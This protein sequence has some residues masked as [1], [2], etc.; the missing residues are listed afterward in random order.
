MLNSFFLGK[1]TTQHACWSKAFEVANIRTHVAD[2]IMRGIFWFFM[3]FIQHCFICRPS[4]F[5]VSEDAGIEPRTVATSTLAVRRSNRSARSHNN[6]LTAWKFN[7]CCRLQ[8]AEERRKSLEVSWSIFYI[9]SA[10]FVNERNWCPKSTNLITLAFICLPALHAMLPVWLLSACLSDWGCLHAMP[11]G[12]LL[13][14]YLSDRGCLHAMLPVA[15][16]CLPACLTEAACM[17][18][19]LWLFAVFKLV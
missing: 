17:Q 13:S 14:V 7:F 15:G 9:K 18:C 4:E 12:W 5:S 8:A 19:Y 2:I 10:Q 6:Y 11:P 1:C 3:Y 16:C